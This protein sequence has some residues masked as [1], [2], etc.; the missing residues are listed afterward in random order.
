MEN[1][2]FGSY[3][4]PFTF[5][6]WVAGAEIDSHINST[7]AI[8][9]TPTPNQVQIKLMPSEVQMMIIT[10][11]QLFGLRSDFIGNCLVSIL[12]SKRGK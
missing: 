6:T 9:T 3:F 10:V 1:K 4:V 5:S 12:E 8:R 2:A 11:K 7:F